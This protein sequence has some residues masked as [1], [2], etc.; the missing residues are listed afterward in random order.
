MTW[1]E[2][3]LALVHE[4]YFS[5]FFSFLQHS[6][7]RKK[8]NTENEKC[9]RRVEAMANTQTQFIHLFMTATEQ[10]RK[11]ENKYAKKVPTIKMQCT[12]ISTKLIQTYTPQLLHTATTA[13]RN[14]YGMA[15]LCVVCMGPCVF[16]KIYVW[17]ERKKKSKIQYAE[18][19]WECFT[20][21]GWKQ[22]YEQKTKREKYWGVGSVCDS[23]HT[24]LSLSVSASTM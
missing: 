7:E 5:L 4:S 2:K 17:R 19:K 12:L 20:V 23:F 15:S 10:E 18:R 13:R 21:R 6:D 16:E 24:T 9:N 11:T 8:I 14:L 22:V 3:A 1:L